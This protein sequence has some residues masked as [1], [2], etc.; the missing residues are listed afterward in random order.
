MQYNIIPNLNRG[1]MIVSPVKLSGITERF[2]KALFAKKRSLPSEI[3]SN[4]KTKP[5]IQRSDCSPMWGAD[6]DDEIPM[7]PLYYT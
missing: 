4:A 2:P 5:E 6:D 1:S 3:R 7:C